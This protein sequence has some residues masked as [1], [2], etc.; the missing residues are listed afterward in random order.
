M[1]E[2]NDALN[3]SDD[4]YIAEFVRLYG[5]H[6]EELKR[7]LIQRVLQN[8]SLRSANQSKGGKTGPI[9]DYGDLIPAEEFDPR[10]FSPD[11]SIGYWATATEMSNLSVFTIPRPEWAT[12]VMWLNK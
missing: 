2:Q 3:D 1:N 10:F 6:A 9:P 7:L 12:H 5:G 8:I 11:D 4:P